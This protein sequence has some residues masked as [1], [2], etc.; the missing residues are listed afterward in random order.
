MQVQ[1]DGAHP[2]ISVL[3]SVRNGLPYLETAIRS[4]LSQTFDDFEFVIVDNAST[5]GSIELVE[6][7]AAADSRI[8]FLRNARDLGQSGSLN[9]GL[10]ICRGAW[11]A[12]MDAD[13]AALPARFESQLAFVRDNPDV[14]ATSCL[15]YYI[16]AKDERVGKTFHDLTTR[17]ALRRYRNEGR[18]IG[19]LHPGAL[20][21]KNTLVRVGGYRPAFDP[22][23]DIDLWC[24]ISDDAAV[25]VQPEYLME[26]RVHGGS[27]IARAF[28]LSLQKTLWARDCMR[29]RR[30]S[31]PE[32]VWEDFLAGRKNASWWLRLNR[33]RKAN[34]KRLYRQSALNRISSHAFRSLVEMGVATLLQPAYT[35][36]RIKGQLYRGA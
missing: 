30:A 5:D 21:E 10:E 29:A 31:K 19:M 9:R 18:A 1:Q 33:W 13:D 24:R 25:L 6:R 36:R 32:P 15:A 7:L 23:N 17:E 3:M 8:V 26:Y 34:A 14:K 12:R 20:I 28:R 16:N 22:A 4:I 11:I 2:T 27:D 35:L